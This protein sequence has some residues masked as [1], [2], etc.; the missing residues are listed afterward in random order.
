MSIDLGSRMR[1]I[2][3][4]SALL[5]AALAGPAAAATTYHRSIA[6]APK[7]LDPHKASGIGES[8]I[9]LDLYEGLVSRDSAGRLIPGAAASWNVSGDA[10]AYTFHLRPS[11]WSNGEA[12]TAEDFVLSFRRL[13][14]RATAAPLA[15]P[16]TVIRNAARLR[17]GKAT[18]E[19][20]GVRAIDAET[21]EIRLEA[22]SAILP[23]LLAST[24]ALPLFLRTP[25]KIATRAPLPS[26]AAEQGVPLAKEVPKASLD[27]RPADLA[28]KPS[29][30]VIAKSDIVSAEATGSTG[31]PP[32]SD[33]VS[34]LPLAGLEVAVAPPPEPQAIVPTSAIA[35]AQE[36][37][38]D[39]GPVVNG[40]YRLRSESP[41]QIT[42]VRNEAF[43]EA[44]GVAI[45]EVVYE[46]IASA[47]MALERFEMGGL[48]SADQVPVYGLP[49]LQARLGEALRIA[50]FNG[51]Y[52]YA[53]DASRRP[54]SDPRIRRALAMAIDRNQI[55]SA[56]WGGA[57]LPSLS[58]LPTGL[59]D[60][61]KAAT[62]EVSGDTLSAR[63]LAAKALL[64]QAGFPTD[65][66]TRIEIRAPASDLNRRTAQAVIADWASIGVTG[67]LIE[68]DPSTHYR[69]LATTRPGGAANAAWIGENGDSA[70]FLELMLTDNAAGNFSRYSNVEFDKM[71]KQAATTLDRAARSA[72]LEKA[73]TILARDVAVIPILQYA[74]LSLVS[75]KLKGWTDNV[76]N[77]H[78]SRYLALD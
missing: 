9:L 42:L 16:L 29:E 70:N 26:V 28:A 37:P 50:P 15:D 69:L 1:K 30:A 41:T 53:L 49:A 72:L 35:P 23:E 62:V 21:L 66:K 46:I 10:L 71:L 67:V 43:R 48:H 74:S 13:F 8:A 5:L 54:F 24:A 2:L 61:G 59:P 44:S 6:A 18:P 32:R 40:P 68:T 78:P 57:M 11:S 64:A 36:R 73:D 33:S 22:P 31:A 19:E 17:A 14:D 7:T 60:L 58:F 12:V 34:D 55:A 47:E 77:I 51:S 76:L 20:L 52:Y 63:R 45:A 38:K 25:T 3:F 39:Y 4:A 75:A 27:D 56:I 65:G